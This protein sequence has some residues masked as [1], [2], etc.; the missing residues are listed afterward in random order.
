LPVDSTTHP[1]IKICCISS[2]EE[3]RLALRL[4]A[5]ALGLVSPMPSGPGVLPEE[6]IAEIA[7]C[8]PPP[9]AR[10]LLTCQPA[11]EAIV[12][13]QRRTGADTLQL[14]DR[15]HSSVYPA[16]RAALP[17]VRLV[18]VVHV[19]GPESVAEAV[20][21]APLVDALLLDSGNQA[22]PVKELGGTGRVHDW[23]ISRQ[24]REAVPVPVFLAGGLAAQNVAGALQEVGPYGLDVC[25]GVRTEGR[26]EETKLRRFIEAARIAP[27]G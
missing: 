3:A 24:I 13:Q 6:R 11:A 25:S 17:G 15:L 1:R 20:A 5:D 14:C 21:V 23:R 18:Q 12:R 8:V 2:V 26:L 19:Q 22:L 10:F 4:G 16:L 7:V 9:V 27:F